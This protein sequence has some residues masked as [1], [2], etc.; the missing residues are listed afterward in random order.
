MKVVIIGGGGVVGSTTAFQ[1]AYEGK[2]TEIVLFDARRNMADAHA[3]DIQQ[4]I[5]RRSSTRVYAGGIEDTE[6]SDI[7]LMAAGVPYRQAAASRTELFLDN[8]SLISDIMGRLSILSPTALW[9]VATAPV[10][11]I[12]YLMYQAFSLPRQKVIGLNQNDTSRF[13]LA[14]AET[15]SVPATAV[16]AFVL[17]EHGRNQV[18]IF[19]RIRIH[20]ETVNLTSAQTGQIREKISDFFV[21]WH[22]L[23]PG[24][25]PGWTS[26]VSLGDIIGSFISGDG[27]IWV[28]SIPLEGEYGLKEVSLGVPIKF[29]RDGV[30]EIIELDLD[31]EERSGLEA[32]AA[33]VKRQVAEGMGSLKKS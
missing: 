12:V 2:A 24:R 28:C 17:G 19:S 27:Q 29:G 1:V 14:I 9:I 32:S 6:N 20:G 4:S 7:I 22:N 15:L 30:Q 25:T 13:R 18:P 26:A 23:H 16:E 21:Q 5:A 8:L 31:A 10:D 3:L 33:A 11:P